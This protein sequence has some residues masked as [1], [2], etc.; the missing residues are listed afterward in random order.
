MLSAV[1]IGLSFCRLH[2]SLLAGRAGEDGAKLGHEDRFGHEG[3]DAGLAG[4]PLKVAPI[5][6]GKDNDGDFHTDDFADASDGLDAVHV[7]HEIVH[8]V[9][10]VFVLQLGSVL[11][12]KDG[13]FAGSG[14]VRAHADAAEHLA[15]AAAGIDV[16]IHHQRTGARQLG[17]RFVEDGLAGET[18]VQGDDELGALAFLAFYGDGAAHHVYDIFRDGHAKAGALDATDS[19]GKFSGKGVEDMGNKFFRHADAIVFDGEFVGGVAFLRAK[20]LG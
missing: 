19:G 4:F 7:R 16:I 13:F 14:P 15:Y 20:L 17:N 1:V 3:S 18:H 5:V 9:D 12:A 2:F 8:D 6:S 10:F 11:G